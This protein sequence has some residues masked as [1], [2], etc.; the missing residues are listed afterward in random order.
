MLRVYNWI[1]IPGHVI[2]LLSDLM[3]RWKTRLEIW[4]DGKEKVSKWIEIKCCLLHGDRYSP[5]GF[6]LSEILITRIERISIMGEPGNR[7]IKRTHSLSVDDLKVYQESHKI[8]K[9]MNEIIVQASHDTGACYG[10]AKCAEIVFKRGKMVK[11]EELQVLQERIKTIDLDQKEIYK[12]LAVELADGIKTKE[13]YKRI[14]EKVEKRVNDKNLIRVI[15]TKVIPVAACPMNVCTFTQL[16]LVELDEIIKRE[17]KK[18]SM[19]GRQSSD[20]RLYMNKSTG[21]RGQKSLRE[22][23]E[24]TRLRVA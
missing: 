19:L 1:G 2:K 20:K 12:F 10:V 18:K 15:N 3:K 13:V 16:E 17:L 5:V 23:F 9:D 6:C 21:D 4:S 11:G 8:L 14:K 24:E 7:D 22:V